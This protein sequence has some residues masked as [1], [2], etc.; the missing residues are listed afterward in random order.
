M[1]KRLPERTVGALGLE[2]RQAFIQKILRKLHSAREGILK[3]LRFGL[4]R[5][6]SFAQNPTATT[7]PVW[8]TEC[9]GI[10]SLIMHLRQEKTATTQKDL[11]QVF[12]DVSDAIKF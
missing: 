1:G 5:R 11:A 8:D 4:H 3:R 12:K 9:V 10:G 2:N 7:E 6:G